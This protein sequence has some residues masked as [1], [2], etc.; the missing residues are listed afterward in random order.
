MKNLDEESIGLFTTCPP[1][2][3]TD[4][5][6]YVR[7]V[8]EV[9]RWSDAAGCIGILVY[10]DNRLLDPWL[11]S[12]IILQNSTTLAP[13]VAVQSVYMHPYTVA[14][15]VSTLSY[16]DGRRIYLNMVAGGF[17]NDLS[18]LND[19]TP[20]DKRDYR[21]SSTPQLFSGCWRSIRRDARW[22]SG[23]HVSSVQAKTRQPKR[24]RANM[25]GRREIEE[26]V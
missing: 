1:Y 17:K 19:L 6:V 2:E 15:M 21:R 18:A 25:A 4:A 20:H 16:L 23:M 26:C 24:R 8:S 9:A 5:S 13:L 11:V 3:G 14:K 10:T 22:P 7:Q 12:Q